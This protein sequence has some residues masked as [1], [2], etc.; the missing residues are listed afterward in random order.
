MLKSEVN[1]VPP[2]ELSGKG[3]NILLLM[4]GSIACAKASSLISEW[5]KQGH[6]V[7]VACTRSVA[8]FV[9]PA[10]LQ[11]LGAETVFDNVFAQGSAMEHISLGKWADI[12]IAAPA[13]SNLI[14]K[15]ATGIADDAVTTL[16]Q[17]AYGQGKPMLI[18]PAMNT[19]M[20]RYPAT[21][22]SI[23]RL[24]QWGIHV[25]PVGTGEL[26]CGEQGEGRMLEPREVLQT[27]KRLMAV[28][29]KARGQ[30]IL[31]TA[32]GTREPIDSVRYIGNVSSG[33]TASRLADELT[34]AGH[35]VSWLGADSA[36]T[37]GLPCDISRFCSFD[38]LASQLQRL[39]AANDYD[40]VI[41]AAAVSDFSVASVQG[42]DGDPQDSP[43]GKLSSGSELLLRLKPNPKLLDRI[44]A[45]SKNPRVR[46][47][48]FKL[49]DT[50]DPQQ[51]V[52]AVKKQFDNSKVDAV[53]HNDLT[54]ISDKAH[55]FCLYTSTQAQVSCEDV[56][57]LAK[58]I[59]NLVET[60]S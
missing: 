37:P 53:V 47:I 33:R 49:T 38:D 44:R 14:N 31:V 43:S 48:G 2:A 57:A 56:G 24:K 39:L 51:R 22:E 7:R 13:T 41:H 27:M 19:R 50:E 36:M 9:G 10:T 54:D 21:Q 40:V 30:R 15:L 42:K 58:T 29:R 52:S 5:S 18:V 12:I 8:E 3:A 32:G 59:N 6:K 11:G 46:V 34:T 16:W 26:A 17:A 60:V 55:P 1:G 23:G 28:D 45:W 35:E 20:W 4:S 25:L